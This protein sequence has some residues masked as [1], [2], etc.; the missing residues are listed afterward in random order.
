MNCPPIYEVVG[1]NITTENH[2][3]A[4]EYF[5]QGYEIAILSSKDGILWVK[6]AH[7]SH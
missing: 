6:V 2:R 1:T 5:R 4:V 7:W 3:E